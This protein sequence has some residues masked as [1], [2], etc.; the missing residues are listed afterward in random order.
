MRCLARTGRGLGAALVLAACAGTAAL[1]WAVLGAE[2]WVPGPPFGLAGLIAKHF[3]LYV[4]ALGASALLGV[5][6]Y[7][8]GDRGR[9]ASERRAAGR[10]VLIAGAVLAL[11]FGAVLIG[12][13]LNATG[14]S[15]YPR[16]H[17]SSGAGRATPLLGDAAERQPGPASLRSRLEEVGLHAARCGRSGLGGWSAGGVCRPSP[18]LGSGDRWPCTGAPR[19][20]ACG[21]RHAAPPGGDDRVQ[22][23][24]S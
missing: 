14:E 11:Y 24:P 6:S 21:G 3:R 1:V 10:V 17:D 23:R 7:A 19:T 4:G 15:R 20:G 2:T 18:P 22:S 5:A 13:L 8:L 12:G 16:A 9:A